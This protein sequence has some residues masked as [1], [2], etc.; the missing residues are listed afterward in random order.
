MAL[1]DALTITTSEARRYLNIVE[2]DDDA[3]IDILIAAAIERA[4]EILCRDW[5]AG[6][7]VPET[8]RLACLRMVASWFE[9]REDD[10][11]EVRS[12]DRSIVR[13]AR[14][15]D[16]EIPWN[17]HSLLIPLRQNPGL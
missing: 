2:M 4:D 3:V 14:I 5:E 8:V 7:T 15:A 11:T 10:V 17:A 9:N 6:D 16:A 1:A 13:G 12:G